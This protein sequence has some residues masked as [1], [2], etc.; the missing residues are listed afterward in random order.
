[1]NVVQ[2]TDAVEDLTGIVSVWDLL[3]Q[4]KHQCLELP[5]VQLKLLVV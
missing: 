2:C 4:I 5:F 1:M 3:C